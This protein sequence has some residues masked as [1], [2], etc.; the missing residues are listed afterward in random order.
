[1]SADDGGNLYSVV[2]MT[3]LYPL[4]VMIER[5]QLQLTNNKKRPYGNLWQAMRTTFREE[6]IRGFYRGFS[7]LLVNMVYFKIVYFLLTSV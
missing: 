1:M 4:I 3:A 5:M 7:V 2:L 6:G